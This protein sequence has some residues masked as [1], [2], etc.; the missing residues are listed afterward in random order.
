MIYMSIALRNT[1]I[2]LLRNVS[3]E[4]MEAQKR[5]QRNRHRNQTLEKFYAG[6]KDEKY[7]QTYYEILKKAD[8]FIKTATPYKMAVVADKHNLTY[9]REDISG[10]KHEHF[11]YFDPKHKHKNKT[12]EQVIQNEMLERRTTDDTFELLFIYNNKPIEVGLANIFDVIDK[13]DDVMVLKNTVGYSKRFEYPI[14]VQRNMEH[15]N[16]IEQ[17]SE[18]LHVKKIGFDVRQL[19]FFIDAKFKTLS[20][21][22]NDPIFKE[23]IDIDMVFIKDK[24]GEV[25]SYK[26][27]EY[28]KRLNL[29][30]KYDVIKF[31]ANEIEKIN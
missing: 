30:D 8:I 21:D 10:E 1:E 2:A 26:V 5:I 11:G 22:D 15:K 23:L 24:Y 12:L 31:Q 4:I 29:N 17:L 6:K 19:E 13:K 20:L 27:T 3:D 9:G 16:K 14:K 18:M 25:I 7:V 28:L